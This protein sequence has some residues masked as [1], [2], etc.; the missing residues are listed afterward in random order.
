MKMQNNQI[1]GVFVTFCATQE[2]VARINALFL[3]G[4]GAVV[5]VD[6]TPFPPFFSD[7]SL[8]AF[9]KSPTIITNRKNLGIARALN[10]GCFEALRQGYRWA[11]TLDQDTAVNGFFVRDLLT[12]Y[13]QIVVHDR[14]IAVLGAN[15]VDRNM[16]RPAHNVIA[17]KSASKVK[18]VI[19]SGSLMSLEVFAE[20][21]GFDERM[22]I[23][24]VD[25]DYCFRARRA[26]YSVWRTS[27]I[28]MQHSIGNVSPCCIA[29]F[30][31]TLPNHLP[32]RRYY[33]FRNTLLVVRRYG[34]I[35]PAWAIGLLFEYLP[36][37][38]VKACIFENKRFANFKFICLGIFDFICSRYS[39]QIL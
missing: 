22:F 7:L 32:E 30:Q 28:L 20:L 16:G 21:T 33:I 29:G 4:V 31:F 39:R 25:T 37:L 26:G 34:L 3:Q 15:Y 18:D 38:A 13:E 6:N 14:K 24:M 19:T 1:C 9:V 8:E 11:T 5:V 2:V 36:K 12:V 10:Q 17:S 23:D 35:D 27:A